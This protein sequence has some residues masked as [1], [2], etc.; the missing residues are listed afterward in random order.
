MTIAGNQAVAE[1]QALERWT[2]SL[3]RQPD[4][5]KVIVDFS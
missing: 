3:E 4:D 1:Q 5:I 2:D